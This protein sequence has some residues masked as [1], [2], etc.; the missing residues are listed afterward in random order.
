ML[1][2][3][4]HPQK[5][6]LMQSRKSFADLQRLVDGIPRRD[7]LMIMG[8]FNAQL[9]AQDRSAWDGAL[10]KFCLGKHITGNGTKLLSFCSA[11]QLVVRNT[12]FQQKDIHL[13]TWVGPSGHL[14]NQIDYI[15]VRK[16]DAISVHNC[17]A[18][19]GTSL[20]SDHRLVRAKCSLPTHC[21][22]MRRVHAQARV[23]VTRLEDAEVAQAFQQR[24]DAALQTQ[25]H[26]D[27]HA[28]WDSFLAVI[29]QAQ[30]ELLRERDKPQQDWLTEPTKALLTQKQTAWAHLVRVRG[31]KMGPP[32]SATGK[33]IQ[34]KCLA[35]QGHRW[36]MKKEGAPPVMTYR[37]VAVRHPPLEALSVGPAPIAGWPAPLRC[38][39]MAMPPLEG[40]TVG[41][42]QNTGWP[43]PL[44]F[45]AMAMQWREPG[46][47]IAQPRML[48]AKQ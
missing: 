9:G 16:A 38:K 45:K 44:R 25:S 39:A 48:H 22:Q 30:K 11:N 23:D 8:D 31:E 34:A 12:F 20:E 1:S 47:S 17:R 46:S 13:A 26:A 10:G 36:D 33:K 28:S 43:A 14:G 19:K 3:H 37:K 18:F 5:T 29:Q 24:V 32:V 2:Q 7:M 35:F 41:P 42:A 6:R 40:L 21:F 4:M 27:A 15:I